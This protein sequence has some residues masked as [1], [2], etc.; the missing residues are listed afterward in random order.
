[1]GCR[2]EGAQARSVRRVSTRVVSL[3]NP[4]GGRGADLDEERER[5]AV[6][7][8]VLRDRGWAH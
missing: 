5:G 1:M 6:M 3:L 2:G 8:L 7:R 4:E